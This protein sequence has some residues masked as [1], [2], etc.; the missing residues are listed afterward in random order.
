MRKSQFTGAKIIAI[1][2]ECD[3]EGMTVEPCAK[4]RHT[5]PAGLS[6]PAPRVI[7]S[8]AGIGTPCGR[9]A[10][11]LIAHAPRRCSLLPSCYR[12]RVQWCVSAGLGAP[13]RSPTCRSTPAAAKRLGCIAVV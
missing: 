9:T 1:V 4:K 8:S 6:R 7:A 13:S 10:G 12:G 3:A 2:R 11:T 5:L